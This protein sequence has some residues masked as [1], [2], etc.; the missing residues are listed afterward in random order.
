MPSPQHQQRQ[1]LK[2]CCVGLQSKAAGRRST[3][4]LGVA[5]EAPGS[6]AMQTSGCSFRLART[7]AGI[8]VGFGHFL[9]GISSAP[10][11]WASGAF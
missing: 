9:R 8:L 6:G 5:S 10:K 4:Q 1:V 3:L 11:K 2:G 7:K